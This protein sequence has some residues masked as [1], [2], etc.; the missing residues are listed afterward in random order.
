MDELNEE[1]YRILL[2]AKGTTLCQLGQ[3]NVH[4]KDFWFSNIFFLNY[5][6]CVCL[7]TPYPLRKAKV[8]HIM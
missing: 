3:C 8:E 2:N 5:K 1:F 4:T 7:N 6:I